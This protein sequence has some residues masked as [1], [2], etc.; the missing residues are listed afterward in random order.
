LEASDSPAAFRQDLRTNEEGWVPAEFYTE[1]FQRNQELRRA[2]T[3]TADEEF[4]DKIWRVWP[5]KD[6]DDI[7]EWKDQKWEAGPAKS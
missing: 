7:S 3:D 1:S 5:F 4:R 2:I 6:D